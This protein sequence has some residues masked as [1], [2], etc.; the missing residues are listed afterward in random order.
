MRRNTYLTLL[1]PEEARKLWFERLQ[2]ASRVLPEENV[3]LTEALHRVLSRPVAARAENARVA[4]AT[5]TP[6]AM[7]STVTEGSPSSTPT[8][9]GK[10]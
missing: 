2:A 8:G 1:A 3:P 10:R 6:S 4:G 5:C 9:P 7:S